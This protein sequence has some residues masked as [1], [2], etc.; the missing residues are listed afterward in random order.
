[1]KVKIK[2]KDTT[3]PVY[4]ENVVSHFMEGPTLALL[5]EGG[6]VRN[7][8]LIHIWYYETKQPRE[9]TKVLS[10]IDEEE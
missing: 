2:L 3:T 1:M 4:Y 6:E 10:E 9:K 8:P 7:F 5:F